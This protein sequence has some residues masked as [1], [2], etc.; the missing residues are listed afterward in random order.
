MSILTLLF[1]INLAPAERDL[2]PLVAELNTV[3]ARE[4]RY[5]PPP[6][7]AIGFAALPASGTLRS[8]AGAYYPESGSIE[9]APDLDLTEAFGQSYL[10]HELVHAAQYANDAQASAR[11]PQTLEAEAYSVQSDFLRA[12]GLGREAMLMRFL[13]DQLGSCAP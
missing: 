12:H 8:Q 11:C 5:I 4:T 7:P 1:L 9:L 10:L 6:C 2:C 13:A 3:I